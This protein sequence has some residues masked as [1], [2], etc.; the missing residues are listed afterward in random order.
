[1]QSVQQTLQH[2]LDIQSVLKLPPETLDGL[3]LTFFPVPKKGIDKMRGF[4][5]LRRPNE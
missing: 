1:M 2:Y 3:W 4:V 5:D